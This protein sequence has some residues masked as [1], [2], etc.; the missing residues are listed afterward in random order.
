MQA[1]V[2]ATRASDMQ[3]AKAADPLDETLRDIAIE[4]LQVEYPRPGKWGRIYTVWLVGDY[5]WGGFLVN[6]KRD[7]SKMGKETLDNY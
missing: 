4:T 6:K 5:K 2:A 1:V 7:P 3:T